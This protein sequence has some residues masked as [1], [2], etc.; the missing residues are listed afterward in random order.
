MDEDQD[1]RMSTI[2]FGPDIYVWAYPILGVEKN[3]GI[4]M[5]LKVHP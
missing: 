1:E 2:I 3:K 4:N 5:L